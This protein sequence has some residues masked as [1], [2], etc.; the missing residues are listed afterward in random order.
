MLNNIAFNADAIKNGVWV[1]L[2]QSS[3]LVASV[4]NS[5]F[6]SAI[7][8][9]GRKQFTDDEFCSILA[10]FILLDWRDVKQPNGE[11]LAYSEELAKIA[12]MS[13]DEVRMLVDHVSTD[14]KYFCE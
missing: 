5:K 4:E 7:F 9:H 8:D 14:L 6:K 2:Q 10:K 11:D 12:L 3:F 1:Q 13:N